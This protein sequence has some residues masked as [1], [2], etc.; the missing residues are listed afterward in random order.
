MCVVRVR[1]GGAVDVAR[2][3]ERICL[4]LSQVVLNMLANMLTMLSLSL[5]FFIYFFLLRRPTHARVSG[6]FTFS[7][8]HPSSHVKNVS[9]EL[10]QPISSE[11]V[12]CVG[13]V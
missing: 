7:T 11:C 9:A 3:T 10:R 6:T 8:W 4:V 12:A 5:S 1:P 2:L 13:T